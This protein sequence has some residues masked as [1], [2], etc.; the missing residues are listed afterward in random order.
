MADSYSGLSSPDMVWQSAQ[1]DINTAADKAQFVAPYKIRV[2]R[3]FVVGMDGQTDAGGATVKFDS[4]KA[5]TRGDG[6][7]AT[8]TVPSA[9]NDSKYI[10]EEP[11]TLVELNP[12]NQ[13]IVEVTAEGVTGLLVCA[14]LVY[15]QVPEVLGN[16]AD[17]IAG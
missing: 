15:R 11:S 1:F 6:D 17:A 3:A 8:I 7:V 14:G 4:V 12:G 5:S 13:V 2:I 16:A 10:Y 9:S